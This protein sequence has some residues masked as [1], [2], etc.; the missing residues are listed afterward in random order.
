MKQEL[1]NFY[2]LVPRVGVGAITIH[3]GRILLVERGGEPSRGLWAIPGG[4][5]K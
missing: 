1:C 4:T 2:P 3:E 5:L